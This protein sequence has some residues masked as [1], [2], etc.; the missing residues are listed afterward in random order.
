MGRDPDRYSLWHSTKK[1]Y[2][3]LN[4]ASY[5]DPRADRA[6]EEGREAGGKDVRK[7]HYL[8]FQRLFIE[9][10]PAIFLYHPTF[11]YFVS[12]RF[13]GVALDL[14]FSSSER[15]WNIQEWKVF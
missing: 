7:R 6:L 8:N 13:S 14:I 15:F 1:E 5:A 9:D 11:S 3:G 4:I 2:P 10:K 12:R